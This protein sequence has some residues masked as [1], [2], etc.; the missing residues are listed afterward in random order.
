MKPIYRNDAIKALLNKQPVLVKTDSGS[1]FPVQAIK[2][3]E[4]IASWQIE[5]GEIV[6]RW[7]WN[8]EVR[9][10]YLNDHANE[11]TGKGG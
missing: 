4:V 5:T 2:V 1:F 6:T 8:R 7:I 10:F 9:G 3:K 11:S